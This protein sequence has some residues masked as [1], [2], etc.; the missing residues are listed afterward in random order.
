MLRSVQM[1]RI[2][3]GCLRA[4]IAVENRDHTCSTAFV[5]RNRFSV[6]EPTPAGSMASRVVFCIVVAVLVACAG[7]STVSNRACSKPGFTSFPFCNASLPLE[8]RLKD[9]IARIRTDLKPKLLT[10]VW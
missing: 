1:A 4:S 5:R 6:I 9:L 3:G 7:A 8:T 10:G 2:P